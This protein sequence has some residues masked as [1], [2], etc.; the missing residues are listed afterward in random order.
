MIGDLHCHTK[1]SDGSMGIEELVAYA[2]RMGLD[3]L[4]ITDHDTMAGVKRASVLCSRY[5]VSLISGVE[6]S[7]MDNSRG[8]KAHILCYLP[9]KTVLIDS[10]CSKTIASRSKAGQ[11][12]AKEVMKYYPIVIEN[13]L[14]FSQGSLCIYK[15]HIMCALMEA[16]YTNEMFGDLFRDLFDEKDGRVFQ[17]VEYPD[18][19]KALKLIKSAGGIAVLAH[20]G[21]YSSFELAEEMAE[22]KLIS[23]LELH[24]P[25]NTEEDKKRILELCDK[26]DLI[27]T[28]GTDF[29]GMYAKRANPIATC[30]S[31]DRQINDL[32]SLKSKQ[33]GR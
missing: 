29:H 33:Q 22:K 19:T 14:K 13:I 4:A 12:M 15:Q 6:I 9:D 23:G 17:P 31:T 30:M 24:H 7:V 3:F 26:Y 10:M 27:T 25:R 21:V 32:F 28:G 20:P 2:K 1:L 16:G 8:R 11:N 5:G 18:V